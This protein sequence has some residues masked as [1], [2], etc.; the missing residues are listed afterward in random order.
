MGLSFLNPLYLFGA[1]A[2]AVPVVIHLINRRRAPVHRFAALAYLLGAR[3]RRARH[4]KL[5][6]LLLLALRAAAL[7]LLALA[8]ARPFLVLGGAPAEA[9]LEPAQAAVV[10]DTSMSM[11]LRADGVDRLEAAKAAALEA[12]R[13]LGPGA[14]VSV[15]STEPAEEG[16]DGRIEPAKPLTLD[17]PTVRREV[18]ALR[19]GYGE[20][21]FRGALR[22]AYARL[23]ESPWGRREIIVATD[24]A[25]HG[26][27][28]VS[29]L[30]L[31][32]A[33]PGIGIRVLDVGVPRAANVAVAGVTPPAGPLAEGLVARVGARIANFGPEPKRGVLAQLLLDGRKVDQKLL[34]LPARGEVETGFAVPLD[35]AAGTPGLHVGTVQVAAD[36]LPLD[37]AS[38]FAYESVGKLD[39]VVVDGDPKRTLLAAE[40]HYLVQALDPERDSHGALILP[41]VV[42]VDELAR[43]DLS[44]AR[45][46]FLLNAPGLPEG[47]RR[48]LAAFVERGGGLVVTAGDQVRPDV[49]T[50][51]LYASGTRLLPGPLEKAR[52]TGKEGARIRIA[53]DDHPALAPFGGGSASLLRSARVLAVLPVRVPEGDPLVRTLLALD[54]GTPLLVERKQGAGRIVYLATTADL[55]WTDLPARAAFLPLVQ[56]LTLALAVGDQPQAEPPHVVGTPRRIPV[57]GAPAGTVIRITDPRG[58]THALTVAREQRS[59]AAAAAARARRRQAVSSPGTRAGSSSPARGGEGRGSPVEGPGD[60]V[61][62]A[63]AEFRGVDVPGVYRI[64][65]LG[66]TTAFVAAPA[67]AESDLARI[68]ERELAAKLPRGV[69]RVVAVGDGAGRPAERG[70]RGPIAAHQVDLSFYILASLLVVLAAESLLGARP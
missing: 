47:T 26:W 17:R 28:P 13:R 5:R 67:K 36:A 61:G 2:A 22:R 56:S 32:P 57:D 1:L 10:V 44:K 46:V 45:V 48:Q 20:A 19:V 6:H 38:H 65:M 37:D 68:D 25:R 42:T 14:R 49:A 15:L 24:L 63:Y 60:T 55:D 18:E 23:A 66:R 52:P 50:R 43:T 62:G 40:S 69:V 21:D 3:K 41:R 29:L 12:T 27:E 31:E 33:D 53:A 34:D 8:L 51:E 58:R 35:Q 59:G 39:V 64:E 9:G 54:D 30:A 7:A 16:Q 4:L 11:G 70:D